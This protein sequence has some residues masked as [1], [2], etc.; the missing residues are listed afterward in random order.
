MIS[1]Q[2]CTGNLSWEG[3]WNK[4]R[5]VYILL[6]KIKGTLKHIKCKNKKKVF[7]KTISFIQIY[8]VLF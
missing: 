6:K 3:T 7:N 4:E 8:D 1:Q 5:L 2:K